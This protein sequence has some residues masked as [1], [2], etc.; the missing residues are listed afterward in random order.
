[1]SILSLLAPLNCDQGGWDSWAHSTTETILALHPAA[2]DSILGVPEDLFLAEILLLMLRFIDS[3]ALLSSKWTVQ[4]LNSIDRTHLVQ[5]DSA[6][7]N[8]HF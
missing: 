1:M 5:Q 6:T 3:T 2:L 8:D 7:K 4:K